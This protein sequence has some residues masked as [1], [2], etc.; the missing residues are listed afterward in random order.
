MILVIYL[1]IK[2]LKSEIMLLDNINYGVKNHE[3]IG[4]DYLRKLN[5]N[6]ITC[7]LVEN[8]IKIK[9]IYYLKIKITIKNYPML[10]NKVLNFKEG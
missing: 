6:K 3:K 9:D 4:A 7:D 1:N 10:Q 5:F 8:H 2:I